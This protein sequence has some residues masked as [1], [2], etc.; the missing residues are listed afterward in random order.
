MRIRAPFPLVVLALFLALGAYQLQLPG[1]HYDEAKEAGLNAMQ[2]VLGGP[3]TAFRDAVVAIGPLRIP[4]MVQD[5]IGA[6]NV[7][8]AVPFLAAGGINPV[9]LRWLP[10]LC[11]AASLL[12]VWRL[13]TE[14]NGRIAGGLAAIL[15]AVN[16]TYIFW[17][18]QGI[19]V[20]NI[21]AL[22]FLAALLA[23]TRWWL[24]GRRRYLWLLALCCG[25][26][27]YAKLLFAWGIGAMVAVAALSWLA[28]CPPAA[29]RRRPRAE[30]AAWGG[31]LA[32]FIAP[33]LPLIVF[34]VQ[35]GGTVSSIVNNL[36]QSYYGV[37]NSAYLPNLGHRLEQ[38]ITVLRGDHLWYLG[39]VYA[40]QVAPAVA[41]ALAAVAVVAGI[42]RFRRGGGRVLLPFALLAAILLQSAFTVSDLFVTHHVLTV[43]LIAL[44]AGAAAAWLVKPAWEKR[45]RETGIRDRQNVPGYVAGALAV[46]AVLAWAGVDAWNTVRYHQILGES[47]GYATHSDAIYRLAEYLD[48]APHDQVLALDWGLD[49]PL[50]FLTSGRVNPIEVFGYA[51]LEAPDP[52]FAARVGPYLD[53]PET[54][55]V[56]HVPDASIFRGREVALAEI[57]KAQG[58]VLTPEAAFY[59]RSGRSLFVVYRAH[60]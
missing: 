47:G 16:P 10:L 59:L 33:L 53:R 25:L 3:V 46:V 60:R 12:L 7:L 17:S 18:R 34:N 22:F 49:A 50:R 11:G 43:P 36:G 58:L 40:N 38:V 57:A 54:L 5:Y 55:Y 45:Q 42:L 41:A 37:D 30:A 1:L 21:T 8:L 27:L 13:G 28:G 32:C 44:S 23:G 52:G 6:L 29:W 48:D 15:L 4:L 14:W 2:L 20:T 31:A 39:E 24:T 26:G 51:A 35:T 19:F 9:A 56:S